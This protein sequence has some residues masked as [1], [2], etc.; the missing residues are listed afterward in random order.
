M[1]IRKLVLLT[2][3]ASVLTL[4]TGCELI[5]DF[6]RNKIDSAMMQGD[7]GVGDACITSCGDGGPD[8]G[9]DSGD[10]DSGMMDAAVDAGA[11][12]MVDAGM[13]AADD[14]SGI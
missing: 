2:A 13:D 10:N 1:K 12:A 5:V 3:A 6:D 4:G 9:T 8:G 7:T 14:D 11:D